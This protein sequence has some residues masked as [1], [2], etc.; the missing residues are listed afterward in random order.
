M[1]FCNDFSN[2]GW[3][4]VRP[5]CV[6]NLWCTLCVCC[7]CTLYPIVVPLPGS[8]LIGR[9]WRDISAPSV[10]PTR[11]FAPAQP[12]HALSRLS[13]SEAEFG[14]SLPS[15]VAT[16]SASNFQDGPPCWCAPHGALVA[17]G[18]AADADVE[19]DGTCCLRVCAAAWGV[20][21]TTVTLSPA[22][23]L[24]SN[25]MPFITPQ[26]PPSLA[27]RPKRPPPRQ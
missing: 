19:S 4:F 24:H 22:T 11:W 2:P 23:T 7:V 6:C 13:P 14:A 15:T 3:A 20:M 26:P 12:G 16:R 9:A 8:R 17:A 27:R 1:G 21:K 10:F 18:L 5:R 25:T